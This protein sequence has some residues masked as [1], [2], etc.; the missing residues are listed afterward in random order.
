MFNYVCLSRRSIFLVAQLVIGAVLI[1]PAASAQ[2]PVSD[3]FHAASLNQNLWTFVNP[4][5][6]A[7]LTMTGTNA[8]INVPSG[9]NHELWAN[10]T[11]AP[12]LMQ[13]V[14]NSAS[15][16]FT[17]EA[18]FD[19]GLVFQ[20]QG[21]QEE[22]IMVEQ[23]A[24]T[25]IRFALFSGSGSSY[26]YIATF[27][28]GQPTTITY[29]AVPLASGQVPVW[30]RVTRA[31]NT[32]TMSWSTNG[33]TYTTAGSSFNYTLTVNQIGPYAAN[34]GNSS[35]GAPAPA[36]TASIDYFFNT[37]SPIS[38]EDGGADLTPT[39]ISASPGT[40]TATVNWN[41]ADY[42]SSRVDYGL[43]T[44]YGSNVTNSSLVTSHALS[45]PA[46]TC[47]TTYHFK[48]TS[49]DW[50]GYSVSSSDGT[51]TTGSC[52]IQ[53]GPTISNV[54]VT[55]GISSA[56]VAWTTNVNAS[57]RVDYGVSNLYGS[58]VS[59]STLVTTHSLSLTNLNCGVLY[60]YAVTSVDGNGN[61][62]TTADSTFS[63]AGCGGPVSD[64]FHGSTL[65]TSLWT[66]VAPCCGF[67]KMNGTDALLV[68]PP[69][70]NHD[71]WIT[72][73]QTIRLM[74]PTANVNFQVEV[75]FDTPVPVTNQEEGIIVEQDSNTFMRFD[76]ISGGRLYAA[77][78]SNGT[79]ATG[80]IMSLSNTGAPFWLR[81]NRSGDTWTMFWSN[82][83]VNFSQGPVITYHMTANR[84]GPSAGNASDSNAGT[85]A[86]SLTAAFDYFFNTA[87]PIS[88]A[89]GGMAQPPNQ[90]TIN[91]WYGDSQAFGQNGTPQQ[92][93]N[94]LGNVTAPSGIKSASYTL[95]G[96]SP[97][98]LRVGSNGQRLVDTG[99]F[100]VEIDHAS[101]NSGA[102]T[103]VITATDNQN[104]T[105]SHTVTVNYTAGKV[106]TLPYSI[107]WS[108]VSN[109]QNVAQVVDGQ[110]AIQ[111]DGTV[112]TMQ[113]GDDR[114][115]D[116]GDVTWTD[117]QVTVQMTINALECTAFG[118]GVVIGWKG[119]TTDP[120]Q[121]QPDQPRTGHPFFGL[122]W[123][124]TT[125]NET[126]AQAK[127]NIYANSPS[128]PETPLVQDTSGWK[129]VL[130]QQYTIKFAVQRN[131][132][133]TSSHFSLKIWPSNTAEPANWNLQADGDASSGSVLLA[134]YDA[135]VSF[136]NVSIVP[137]P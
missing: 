56:T 31:T 25:F 20:S 100:N 49:T 71:A 97:Q 92:W 40:T 105:S 85:P 28:S 111:P 6:D 131:P 82:D 38:P 32:W 16:N 14:T 135:D 60:H 124:A 128:F 4:R 121:P 133:G 130:G 90:P 10:T 119:H 107:D 36:Y 86:P 48:V 108:Q 44:S 61:S 91:V 76:L 3:D 66:F 72:G 68:V 115:I 81:V 83:G 19:S 118:P 94:I 50:T 1:A 9:L 120:T 89:D 102:N 34:A 57:S 52:G 74:Q 73:D 75:K 54:A 106:W 125:G 21:S 55:P 22:G 67:V 8:V 58:F 98:F 37:A 39:S 126:P 46:L 69:G 13:A 99:D 5:G 35:I 103:V 70:E 110:W 127:L 30:I 113:V 63:T 23:D 129:P 42:S 116:I 114:L 43:N 26:V 17:V 80:G 88:P 12:R 11:T 47:A 93:V 64:D 117:Y 122:G 41:T 101:L 134:A 27:A 51:F 87:S 18:K 132:N 104:H 24:Q 112:R 29:T 62:S 96:G 84:I 45:V 136:G 137:L 95:N 79:V 33:S 123:Y 77:A 59:D 78:I 65:N 53:G 7:T 15:V 109:I 2:A